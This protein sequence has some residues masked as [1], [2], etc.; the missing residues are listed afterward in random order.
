MA[1]ICNRTTKQGVSITNA[2]AVI[3]TYRELSK[4][5]FIITVHVYRSKQDYLDRFPPIE[6]LIFQTA[7][8]NLLSTV[9]QRA[10]VYDWLMQQDDFVNPIA[11][12]DDDFPVIPI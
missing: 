1:I 2:H 12:M 9:S 6:C 3:D 11:D 8:E 4:V 7:P 5:E 10:G